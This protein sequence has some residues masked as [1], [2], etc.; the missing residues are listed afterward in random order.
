VV[1]RYLR[2]A[3]CYGGPFPETLGLLPARGTHYPAM[4]A[5]FGLPNEI[6]PGSIAIAPEAVRGVHITRLAHDGS[7]KAGT[8]KDKLMIGHSQGWPIVLAAANDLLGFAIAEGI[9]NALSV[10]EATGLGAWAAGSASRLPS[11][12]SVIPGYA[13]CV[14]IVVDDDPDGRRHA[15]T[16]GHLVSMRGDIEVRLIMPNKRAAA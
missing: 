5:A 16:L 2:D 15:S 9:E 11:L 8:A 12:A 7:A 4:I 6:E 1:E 13:D 10:H 14:T 3:R